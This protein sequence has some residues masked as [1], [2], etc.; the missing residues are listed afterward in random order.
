MEETVQ[1]SKFSRV[2]QLL[3]SHRKD[4]DKKPADFVV[5]LLSICGSKFFTGTNDEYALK[6]YKTRKMSGPL[7]DSF[8]DPV[9]REFRFD[10]R[11][12]ED[13]LKGFLNLKALSVKVLFS[14]FGVNY[15]KIEKDVNLLIKAI[16]ELIAL[17]A[18]YGEDH[19][20]DT[21]RVIYRKLVIESKNNLTV[22]EKKEFFFALPDDEKM[23]I[24]QYLDK[25]KKRIIKLRTV[26][27]PSTDV[28]FYDIYVK[29]SISYVETVYG[30]NGAKRE[31]K[32]IESA[33]LP[34]LF[35]QFDSNLVIEASGGIGKTMFMKHLTMDAIYS[36]N[37]NYI[38]PILIYARDYEGQDLEDF[39]IDSCITYTSP[40]IDKE[41]IRSLMFHGMCVVLFDG[42]DEMN[43][44]HVSKFLESL[45][46]Y[47]N[48]N[49]QSKFIITTRPTDSNTP[50]GFF[51]LKLLPFSQLQSVQLVEKVDYDEEIK[52][53]FLK[54]LKG[55]LFKSHKEFCENPLLLSIMLITFD[56]VGIP[57]K[58]YQF[59]KKV[60]EAMSEKYNLSSGRG[61]SALHCKISPERM[62]DYIT[63]FS[64]RVQYD[65]KS[66]FSEEDVAYYLKDIREKNTAYSED[67]TAESFIKDMEKKL[68]L[69]YKDGLRYRFIHRSFQEYFVALFFARQTDNKLVPIASYLDKEK[70]ENGIIISEDGKYY[71]NFDFYVD[72]ILDMLFDMCHDRIE[73]YVFIPFLHKWLDYE[74]TEDERFVHFVSEVFGTIRYSAGGCDDSTHNPPLSQVY[75]LIADEN[76]FS[77]EQDDEF[78]D[79]GFIE[80]D[81]YRLCYYRFIPGEPNSDVGY[82]EQISESDL[83]EGEEP[84]GALFEVDMEEV[85]KNM[86]AYEVFVEDLKKT[87]LYENF[88]EAQEALKELEEKYANPSEEDLKKLLV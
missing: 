38:V 28:N 14:E 68:C 1:V 42:L 85:L 81:E 11:G 80:L 15:Q 86:D 88:K 69:F 40:Q 8:R 21:T 13:Y 12:G 39:I 23:L 61:S 2:L 84:F 36:F 33:D 9:N 44:E 26:I 62:L 7:M 5:E 73:H 51:N 46:T 6:F 76:V 70:K 20:S 57:D 16:I 49:E 83:E 24:K 50:E 4:V 47:A 54:L 65:N 52:A 35:Y 45:K 78:S 10:Y 30:E 3:Y 27:D 18:E 58:K 60:Y 87:F 37:S 48:L 64:F 67:F 71:F 82:L 66:S 29:N 43:P 72:N 17:Y 25:T 63:I 75:E 34:T 56:R 32:Q 79:P 41:T 74:G 22:E 55:R 53:K 19:V 31:E 59:Y 77:N